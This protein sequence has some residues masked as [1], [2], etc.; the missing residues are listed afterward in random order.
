ML[1]KLPANNS[2]TF[3]EGTTVDSYGAAI[4][5]AMDAVQKI[6]GTDSTHLLATCSGGILAAMA[7][8]IETSTA[9]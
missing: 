1:Q 6:T 4:V 3:N 2:G 9:E 7:R 8:A 5:E